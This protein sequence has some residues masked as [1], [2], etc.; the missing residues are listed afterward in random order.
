MGDKYHIIEGIQKFPS[1]HYK[2]LNDLIL[3]KEIFSKDDTINSLITL[4]NLFEQISK[5]LNNLVRTNLNS[6]NLQSSKYNKMTYY[7]KILAELNIFFCN[8]ILSKLEPKIE[9]F[10]FNRD[11]YLKQLKVQYAINLDFDLTI[12]RLEPLFELL[13]KIM[14]SEH[15]C[16]ISMLNVSFNFFICFVKEIQEKINAFKQIK[17]NSYSSSYGYENENTLLNLLVYLEKLYTLCIFVGYS[18]FID[19]NDIFNKELNSEDWKNIT[20]ISYEVICSG[21]K[22]IQRKFGESASESEQIVTALLNSYNENSYGVTN[23]ALYASKF[24]VYGKSLLLMKIDS[25]KVQIAQDKN[26]TKELMS[27]VRWPV[28]KKIMRRDYQS[29]KYRKKF[30]I[31]KEYPDITLEYIQKLLKL[32]G[33]K[34]IDVSNIRQEITY[35]TVEDIINNREIPQNELFSKKPPKNL[36]KYYV[37]ATLLHSSN[38][39]FLYEKPSILNPFSYFQDQKTTKPETLMI[40]IHGGGFIG[41]STHSHESFLRD[42]VN[43]FNIPIIGLN[44]ALSPEHKYPCGFNDVY[45]GYRWIINHC[46]DVLGFNP[47]KIILSGDSSG[48]TFVLSLIYLLIAKKE[49]E[50]ENIR[51]PD[52]VIPLYPCCHTWIENMGMSLLLSLKDFLLNDKFLLYVNKAYRDN[53]ANDDDPF[54][55]P[56]NVKDC[57]LKKLPRMVFQFGSCDPLRDDIVRLLAKIAK[58]KGLNVKAYEF[59]EY[60]HGWNGFVKTEFLLKIPKEILFL[61]IKDIL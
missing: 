40:F 51:M 44:Y 38:I 24:F 49:F 27:I 55:N 34:D 41:M 8:S 53:Y 21:E 47:K 6:F 31:K 1:F 52:L 37:S 39:D 30:Y 5:E 2:E 23:A 58:I 46:G 10:K 45:Q 59:R 12:K 33:N 9:I 29:I 17:F 35:K 19:E 28:F 56:V 42:W 7:Y 32:M 16:A 54:L 18:Y 60:N 61:E 3:K 25:K 43:K 4:K 50:N 15:N 57:I 26:L 13:E 48:G 11:E 20:K 22:D 14:N 36:K